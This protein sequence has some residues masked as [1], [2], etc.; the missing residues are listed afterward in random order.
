MPFTKIWIHLIWSV[1]NRDKI[2]SKELKPLL[3]EHIIE[4]AK[5]KGIFIKVVNC[6]SDHIHF[7]ISLGRE[8][9]ISKVV[10]LI[11]GESSYWVNKNKLLNGKFE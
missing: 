11:K 4:N 10:M 2:I 9:S 5:Q 6:V 7:L 3:L 1:K 8:Q